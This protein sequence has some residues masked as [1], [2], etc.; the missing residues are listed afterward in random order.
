[1]LWD[2]SGA[3]WSLSCSHW[4]FDWKISAGLVSAF[5]A[6][7]VII[8]TLSII[9]SVEDAE[10][11]VALRDALKADRYPDGRPVFTPLVAVSLLVF[12]VF[13]LQC[14]STLAIA[15]RETNTWR[16]PVVMWLY[17][18]GLAYLAALF[19]YQGRA[20]AGVFLNMWAQRDLNPRPT[21]YESAALTD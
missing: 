11:G 2:I 16:W 12:F 1:M 15:R 20:A 17:M 6:R 9:Y 7:E 8:S 5:A 3:S 19:V 21:D 18:T 13:A 4:G 10:E 14:M